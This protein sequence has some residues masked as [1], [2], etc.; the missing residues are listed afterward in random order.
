MWRRYLL[1]GLIPLAPG[2]LF[3]DDQVRLSD[4][5]RNV[6][7]NVEST[8]IE[9]SE[10]LSI[11]SLYPSVDALKE[12]YQASSGEKVDIWIKRADGQRERLLGTPSEILSRLKS[13]IVSQNLNSMQMSG[14]SLIFSEEADEVS[15]ERVQK[16]ID[17]GRGLVQATFIGDAVRRTNLVGR[18]WSGVKRL[19][20]AAF[21]RKTLSE[22]AK[23]PGPRKPINW[24]AVGA[25]LLSAFALRYPYQN[26][27]LAMHQER[28][29]KS[30]RF[31]LENFEMNRAGPKGPLQAAIERALLPR[32]FQAL[33][34]SILNPKSPATRDIFDAD[35]KLVSLFAQMKAE[36]DHDRAV[37]EKS[38][39][40]TEPPS[41]PKEREDYE[42]LQ[43]ALNTFE[44][45]SPYPG[46]H[47]YQ[48][49]RRENAGRLKP[50]S[51]MSDDE[52]QIFA[53]AERALQDA[54]ALSRRRDEIDKLM[55]S[56][57]RSAKA[58][59]A[60]ELRGAQAQSSY[61]KDFQG[62]ASKAF[63]EF[64]RTGVIPENP[65]DLM[66]LQLGFIDHLRS[67]PRFSDPTLDDWAKRLSAR[68]SQAQ[69]GDFQ[70]LSD[71]LSSEL[72]ERWRG[73]YR[74]MGL[75]LDDQRFDEMT[76]PQAPIDLLD[77]ES[78]G[79]DA[80]NFPK[81]LRPS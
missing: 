47:D 31:D 1:A 12:A 18:T 9:F 76:K 13:Q 28:A 5:V 80:Q 16:F 81:L 53:E 34:T 3:A 60:T 8:Q 74:Q 40:F 50:A 38:F 27:D 49:F 59:L 43:K 61:L 63:A 51:Q 55:K 58:A 66:I 11:S 19:S 79:L 33:E 39:Y 56:A 73:L 44:I 22:T 29:R 67:E 24:K 17:G 54:Y 26:H 75:G 10:G 45:Q 35:Q 7:V 64:K 25:D 41:D 20:R 65:F 69:R 30:L 78:R 48:R 2:L 71:T 62:D 42:R 32:I 36:R 72:E 52:R 77:T 4:I 68:I 57:T 21:C 14:S 6:S 70:L 15:P 46:L 37:A 23:A